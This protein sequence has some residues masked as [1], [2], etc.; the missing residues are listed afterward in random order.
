V[1]WR[2]RTALA[3]PEAVTAQDQRLLYLTQVGPRGFQFFG[4][5]V[6]ASVEHWGDD[7]QPQLCLTLQP[8]DG[9]SAVFGSLGRGAAGQPLAWR[10]R[11]SPGLLRHGFYAGGPMWRLHER[12]VHGGPLALAVRGRF[13]Q[14]PDEAW[15]D[16][17][18]RLIDTQRRFWE[19][20]ARAAGPTQWL[21]LTPNHHGGGHSGGTLVNQAAVLH[22]PPDFS[23]RSPT[24]EAL[25]AH[26][27][28]HQWFPRRFGGHGPGGPVQVA[29]QYWF[30]E[31]FTDHYTHRLLLASGLWQL[32]DYAA[33][34]TERAQ[35]LLT[36]PARTLRAAEIAPRFF[37]DRE[38]GQQM[39]L[40][41]EWLALRWDAALRRS[42]RGS[43]SATLQR[44]M[45]PEAAADAA[46]GADGP[47]A[48]TRVLAAL[49]VALQGTGVDPQQDIDAHLTRGEP[50]PLA[51]PAWA[52]ALAACFVRDEIERP[53]WALGFDPASFTTRMLQGV[54]P[55]GPAHAAGL[56]DGM[57]LAGW[58]VWGGDVTREVQLQLREAGAPGEPDRVRD[59]S[60]R[61]VGRET[62]RLPRWQ[63]R[64]GAE[65]DAGCQAWRSAR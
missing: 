10:G 52:D 28:L 8:F 61:P 56:R 42:G 6:L 2:V 59:V 53:V 50:L 19:L 55:Q 63:V 30:S 60:Y 47:P 37:S 36:S 3:D 39:Y 4:H 65:A 14:L 54:D 62:L 26:E 21:V 64:P 46:E 34:L 1:R 38:A 12:A 20:A 9:S 11:A 44:L 23:A 13:E 22:A 27:D 24:F 33:R 18:A 29:E 49:G 48:A 43:L 40:R 32:P 58:S 7:T 41:G 57:A 45:R 35:R 16:A 17:A 25:V 15:A 5:G 51:G 31:G